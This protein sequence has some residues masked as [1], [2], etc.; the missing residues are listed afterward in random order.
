MIDFY[1][2]VNDKFIKKNPIPSFAT[3]YGT[4][5]K[6]QLENYDKIFKI[7]CSLTE[8]TI[9]RPFFIMERY[10]FYVSQLRN[11]YTS[12]K[13]YR[14][15]EKDAEAIERLIRGAAEAAD[16]PN[17]DLYCHNIHERNLFDFFLKNC[18][19]FNTFR[20]DMPLNLNFNINF[21][22][23][24]EL[25]LVLQDGGVS[26]PNRV[27]YND[28]VM[29]KE[30]KR[31]MRKLHVPESDLDSVWQIEKKIS[32]AMLS[33]R[34]KHDPKKVYNIFA[35]SKLQQDYSAVD[36]ALVSKY[37]FASASS[38]LWIESPEYVLALSRIVQQYDKKKWEQYFRWRV[39]LHFYRYMD[40]SGY[41]DIFGKKML[42]VPKE[43]PL[44]LIHLEH[45]IDNYGYLLGHLFIH[46]NYEKYMRLEKTLR[47]IIHNIRNAFAE[48][49]KKLEW[50][51]QATRIRAV[52]KLF[53][54]RWKIGGLNLNS[55]SDDHLNNYLPNV[56]CSDNN[57]IQN[58]IDLS[59]Y[60]SSTIFS[61][62]KSLLSDADKKNE[63][64]MH[65]F[66][67]NAYYHSEL[68]EMVFP[69]GILQKPI[70]CSSY[71]NEQNYGS[72]GCII[73]HELVHA[74]DNHGSIFNE[75]GEMFEWWTANDIS[76][77]EKIKQKFIY[78]FS[79]IKIRDHYVNGEL[80]CGENIAD[81]TGLQVALSALAETQSKTKRPIHF[82]NFFVSY[83]KTLCKYD[84]DKFQR[85]SLLV[86]PHCPSQIRVNANVIFCAEFFTAFKL[87]KY[88]KLYFGSSNL[89][90]INNALKVY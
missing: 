14:W 20:I 18:R 68:N 46:I 13:K 40:P 83:A 77:F 60:K 7:V 22:K 34:D 75:H 62:H 73:A 78:F 88:K 69:L 48:K 45:C 17:S 57:L 6:L 52:K 82:K 3:S 15:C 39:Q 64:Y 10:V 86:D 2:Y 9:N 79:N 25:L 55:V 38:D 81:H 80:T 54:I 36:W 53:N 44:H 12:L 56:E 28:S 21:K 90:D 19:Y 23:N 66:E 61:K 65:S 70:F 76:N 41:F 5:H 89:A 85:M 58:I 67:V 59:V 72:I 4:F 26:F 8:N 11:F 24:T 1:N 87:Q 43:K 49:L 37:F 29:C 74:F 84:L 47:T 30:L 51:E 50:M 32:Q 27:Y 16:A 33:E 35:V 63:W 42:G 31:L 71:S